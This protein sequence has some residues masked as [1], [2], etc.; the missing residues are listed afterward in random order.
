MTVFRKVR[1]LSRVTAAYFALF[2]SISACGDSTGPGELDSTGALQSLA[3]GMGAFAGVYSRE[4]VRVFSVFGGIDPII[5]QVD[6]T[7]DGGSQRMFALGLRE[8]FPP[9]TCVENIFSDPS[10]PPEPGVCTPPPLGIALMLWQSHSAFRPPDRL[11][12]IAA[13]VGTSNF[14]FDFFSSPAEPVDMFPAF[15]MFVEGDHSFWMSVSGTL[16]SHVTATSESCAIALPPYAKAG[17][18]SVA[19]FDEEGA[20]AFEEMSEFSPIPS[21]RRLNVTIP[22][23]TVRGLWQTI[24]E[25]QP[26]T[27]PEFQRASHW[28]GRSSNISRDFAVLPL[29]TP[30]GRKR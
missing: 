6:V 4:T 13:D 29:E 17:S 11:L 16:T 18:C 26:F 14:E 15:A 10:F 28:L 7:I 24:T 21:T 27:L 1:S 23:Q 19:N 30:A 9:G 5:D 12:F 2:I 20:I 3:L 25:T 22:R 8:S